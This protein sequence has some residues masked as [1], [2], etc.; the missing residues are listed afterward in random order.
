MSDPIRDQIKAKLF[1]EIDRQTG[2]L[3]TSSKE[4]DYN[5]AI[6]QSLIDSFNALTLVD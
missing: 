1:A 5:A 4:M 6:L 3:A 2:L